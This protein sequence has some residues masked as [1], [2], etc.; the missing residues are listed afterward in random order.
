MEKIR[1][2]HLNSYLKDKFGKRTLKI[3]VDGGFTCPNRDGSKG[4]GGC[5]FCGEMGAGDNIKNRHKNILK[6]IS[7]Q[8]KGF[9]NSYRGERA[10]S[11]IIYFQSFTNTYADISI[12]KERYDTALDSSDK[13]VGLEV[14]TRPDCIDENVAKLLA[15]YKDKYYVCVELGFQTANDHVGDYLNRGY[16]TSDFVNAVGLLRKYDIDVVAHMMIGL[17]GETKEDIQSTLDVINNC[18]CQ[19]IKIHSVY[20]IKNSKLCDWYNDGKY[21]P[22]TLEYYLNAV[23]YVVSNLNKDI[24]VHRI[25]ADPPKDI[26]VSPDWMLRKKVVINAINKKLND[27]DIIQG[28]RRIAVTIIV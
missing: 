20:V 11:F 21:I 3:C 14:A 25:N 16:S 27:L 5:A 10:D 19:G 28:D 7:N 18:G 2:N 4:A 8:V 24:I 6:S 12:L 17:P 22:I 15:S 9:L 23:A 1:Y 26:F 13:I